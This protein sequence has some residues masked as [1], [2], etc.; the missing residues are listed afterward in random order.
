MVIP[1][2]TASPSGWVIVIGSRPGANGRPDRVR[3]NSPEAFAV[4]SYRQ[5]S[6]S[7]L[8]ITGGSPLGEV[9]G[10]YWLADRFQ[11]GAGE[12]ELLALDITVSPALPYR[13]VDPGGVGITPDPAAWGGEI[14]S[15]HSRAFQEV[16]L[17]AAPFIDEAAFRQV[18][19]QFRD[20]LQRMISYGY[21]GIIVNGFLEYVNFDR[22]GD[23]MDIYG[24]DSEYRQRHLVF[25]QKFG[26]LFQYAHHL[27]L[28]VILKTD[29]IA[30]TSPLERYFKQRLG[31]LDATRPELW[32]VYNA[33]L[34][35]LFEVLPWVDGLMIRI[36][37]AGA[38][39]NL[40]GWDYYS[41][42]RVTTP[43]A[44]QTMLTHLVSVAEKWD[45]KIL[46]RT[47]SIGVGDVGGMHTRPKDYDQVLGPLNSPHLVVSTKYSQGDFFSYL[48]LNPTLKAGSQSRLV[49]LQA[50]REF[51]GFGALPNYT[52]PLYQTAL[53]ELR[54]H[55]P[56]ILGVWLWT[57]D[58]GPLRAGPLSL[59]PF[60]GFWLF[61][62]ANVYTT[63][64]LAWD[65][66]ADLAELTHNWVR[67]NFGNTPTTID[68][69]AQ[70][71][72]LS[73][74][75]ILKG[76]Y[77]GSF[78]REQ[79]I[80]LGLEPPPTPWLWD[81]VCG[82]SAALSVVYLTSRA[83][84]ASA[85][86]EGFAAVETVQR[87]QTL[88][89]E[90]DP[91]QVKDPQ[92]LKKLRDALAYEKNLFETLAWY[93]K[94]F[95]NYYAWLD[96]GVNH[97]YGEWQAAYQNFEAIKQS[98][99]ARYGQDLDFPAYNF[100]AAEAG[101]FHARRGQL[102]AWLARLMLVLTVG[103]LGLIWPAQNYTPLHAG[104]L[105][106]GLLPLSLVTAGV[107]IFSSF[108]SIIL[109]AG[110]V[111]SLL[112]FGGVLL[113]MLPREPGLAT[114]LLGSVARPLLCLNGLFMGVTAARGPLYFWYMVWTKSSFR[115]GFL[116]LALV[117]IGWLFGGVYITIL[118][119]WDNSA[120]WAWGTLLIAAGSVLFTNGVLA[121]LIGMDTLL[122]RLNNS[123]ALLPFALS[124]VLGI[125]THLNISPRLPFYVTASGA[126]TALAGWVG[127]ML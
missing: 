57:Q 23:G 49:E 39:Y 38:V 117:C 9:Y 34:E 90:I 3:L 22:V 10:L 73:R 127:Q 95:L 54:R 4:K 79:A 94:T 14:Y 41:A 119:G 70:L 50:R 112:V 1:A 106:T 18:E 111:L 66:T 67:E 108:R 21:N 31:G 97:F 80:V 55:N 96:T 103:L 32:A 125:T 58:G 76:L 105:L 109:A 27:G 59:Y 86:A 52:A 122:T 102:M 53:L 45:K 60:Y 115:R 44:V 91:G 77:I 42:L 114:W 24:P 120:G 28:I 29:M 13:L 83:N 62:D 30:L 116:A 40:N 20:Y 15:H 89:D 6:Q 46:F 7:I 56:N 72:F 88:A 11:A 118:T 84:L 16:I 78:A 121:W 2:L 124:K 12:Q 64:R 17:P 43:A 8:T 19:D 47:W 37:E 126:V 68:R 26:R 61:I 98:H 107:L 81:I 87:M 123:L 113:G 33:G 35:E 82:S 85:V 69:L 51:E 104:P 5:G 65:P 101:L 110:T 63:G 75:A 74:E 25:R 36:G 99:L 92:L 93:R 71:M 48:P 100:F